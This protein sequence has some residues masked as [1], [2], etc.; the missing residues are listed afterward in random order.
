MLNPTTALTAV[1]ALA[2]GTAALRL[3]GLALA[4]R[5]RLAPGVQA[6]LDRGT[7]VLI[8]AVVAVA[9]LPGSRAADAPLPLALPLG[10]LVG[11]VLAWRR[12]PFAVV[13]LA[14][15]GTTAALR[16]LGLG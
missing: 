13:V 10:V 7:V 6:L 1:L 11:A 5:V 15:A 12:A 2:V 8:V 14:A 4:G 3:G 9:T 16:A